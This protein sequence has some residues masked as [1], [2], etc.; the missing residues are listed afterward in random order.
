MNLNLLILVPLLTATGILFCRGL[1]QVRSLSLAGALVQLVL[2]FVLLISFL[3]ERAAGNK[4]PMLF[5][6]KQA[7][8]TSLNINYHIGVDGISIAMI[9]LT[10]FVVVAGVLVSWT[11]ETMSREFFFLLLFLSLGAYG[12][13]IS[14]D[15]FTLFFFLE[16]S[17]IPKFLLIGIWGSGKKEYSA[18]KLALMLMGGSALLFVGLAGLYFNTAAA[19]GGY[20]FD[21]MEIAARKIPVDA[22]MIFF[23]FVFLGFGIFTA[24]FP[25]HTWVP[26]GHASAPT[27]AS[28][29]LA[30]ISMKLGGYGCL[31]VASFLMPEGA[32]AYSWVIILLATIAII[33]GA[34]ATMMQTDL[35]YINAYSSVSH[36]GFVLLGIGM[37]TQTSI[38]GAVLQMV[39]HGLMTALFF[40]VIGMIYTRTHTRQVAQLGGLL[41]V[42]P[43]ISSVFVI[44]GLCSLGL[45]GLS[46]FV[47]EMTVFMGSW[48]NPDQGYRFATIL[49]CASIVVTAVYILRATGQTVMGP[50]TTAH[51][52]LGD[53]AWYERT[54]AVLLVAGI[55]V[56]GLL[57][58]W[59]IEL[60]QPGSALIMSKFLP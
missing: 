20:T 7:W 59:L 15:L 58:F 46:G 9:L 34:F 45:P 43:F 21:L 27:A 30:G 50:V 3:K 14:L 11:V 18:M 37:L 35:K 51:Q 31:R 19:G 26:D 6:Y 53:A 44:A 8:F 36:C 5:E 16:I 42:M 52:Q 40:A 38:V 33:Y 29:F 17:V 1:K 28:M 23:P 57:P 13:F 60:V 2:S 39:S 25:F 10:A 4:A 55:L 22:Q 54:A 32:A 12:Y 56:I 49:A 47:A 41:K 48:Q 24:I